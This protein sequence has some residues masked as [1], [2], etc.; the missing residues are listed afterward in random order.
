MFAQLIDTAEGSKA[1]VSKRNLATQDVMSLNISYPF[2]R[3]AFSSLFNVNTNYSHYK[4]NFGEGRTIDLNAAAFRFFAQ[5]SY[6]FAKTWTAELSG[7]Y[8]APTVVMG[9]FK[10]KSMWNIDAGLQKQVLKGNGTLRATVTDIF[11]T[12]KFRGT[13]EFAGQTTVNKFNFESRQFKINFAYR[14]GN[15]QVKAA[16]QR[17][18]GADDET[19]RVGA[20][21]SG[22]M[23]Q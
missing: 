1:F 2:Q 22:A 9:T 5:N 13:S 12:L 6:K 19:K 17:A 11:H 21:S 16:R 3:K 8:N 15:S 23:G 20:A 4:A 10:M 14:F 7:F 18:T